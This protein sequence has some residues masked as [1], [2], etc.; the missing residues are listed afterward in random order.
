M[1]DRKYL[2]TP[3]LAI[4]TSPLREVP[5]P[6]PGVFP[7]SGLWIFHPCVDSLQPRLF[8]SRPRKLFD[9]NHNPKEGVAANPKV[10]QD[11]TFFDDY[12]AW[13]I[14]SSRFTA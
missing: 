11:G 2:H 4:T 9:R 8:S 7:P 5:D 3:C 13:T 14:Y 6:C 1:I 12:R 10:T